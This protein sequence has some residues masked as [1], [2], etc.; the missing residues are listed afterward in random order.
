MAPVTAHATG[1]LC[2]LVRRAARTGTPVYPTAG[3]TQEHLLAPIPAD[4]AGQ[5]VRLGELTQVVDYPYR[6]LTITVQAGLTLAELRRVLA[7]QGQTLPLD[8]PL[9][10]QATAGGSVAANVNGPRRSGWGTWRDYVIGLSFVNDRGEEVKAGGRVVKNVA[11]YDLCKLMTGSSGTL[12]VI[13]QITLKVRPR[14]EKLA[15]VPLRVRGEHLV[16]V[17]DILRGSRARPVIQVLS[18]L[19]ADEYRFDVGF[20]DS[21]AAVDWQ[22][23]HVADECRELVSEVWPRLEGPEAEQ[24]ITLLTAFPLE[25]PSITIQA[26]VLGSQATAFVHRARPY[27]DSLQANPAV[28]MIVGHLPAGITLEQAQAT[29]AVLRQEAAAFGGHLTLPRCP[30]EWRAALLPWGPL[31]PDWA[32]MRKIKQ[33]LDPGDLFQR[34]RYEPLYAR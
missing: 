26:A 5:V 32:M 16:A 14:P 6:D 25:G 17:F 22:V 31:R 11:G 10:H 27:V 9:P 33:A 2:E 30:A 29:I 19:E 21:A 18:S 7:A 1:D 12:G 13:T 8:V 20:E 34:G 3:G 4:P 28:G 23:G 24:Y 15:I